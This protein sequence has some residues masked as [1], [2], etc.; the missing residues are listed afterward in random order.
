MTPLPASI[1]QIHNNR[2]GEKQLSCCGTLKNDQEDS[3]L[4]TFHCVPSL[5]RFW[6]T[7][8]NQWGTYQIQGYYFANS[9]PW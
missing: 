3:G 2:K 8:P 6:A 4:A 9:Y 5:G 1:S 7:Q